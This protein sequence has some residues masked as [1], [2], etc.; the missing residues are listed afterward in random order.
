VREIVGL[1]TVSLVLPPAILARFAD[2]LLIILPL[3][4]Q[5][6]RNRWAL[7]PKT[8]ITSKGKL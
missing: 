5:T 7:L 2:S 8:L 4:D 6:G 3:L 1:I